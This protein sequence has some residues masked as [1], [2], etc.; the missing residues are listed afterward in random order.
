MSCDKCR[1]W[2]HSDCV[3]YDSTHAADYLCELCNP[4]HV[5]NLQTHT[6]HS[7]K[8]G[9]NAQMQPKTRLFLCGLPCGFGIEYNGS[10]VYC[11]CVGRECRR[12][13]HPQLQIL[14]L[15]AT[16]HP[17]AHVHTSNTAFL[18]VFLCL[19]HSDLKKT[20][21]AKL[22]A[23]TTVLIPNS[24]SKT[25]MPKT[26]NKRPAFPRESVPQMG[27]TEGMGSAG[28]EGSGAGSASGVE[29]AESHPLY[30]RVH[31]HR[32]GQVYPGVC[33]DFNSQVQT[34]QQTS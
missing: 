22:R 13:R 11:A 10:G 1:V 4:E 20:R 9:Q 30:I 8:T 27:S 16:H 25:P 34:Q 24:H 32:D 3:A 2:Q 31:V 29:G 21:C 15:E 12:Y 19:F 23:F 26:P 18:T 33:Y 7:E 17:Q 6:T 14:A 28:A 5:C